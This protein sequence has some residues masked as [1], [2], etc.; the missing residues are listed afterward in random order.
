MNLKSR[1][2]SKL[3][4]KYKEIETKEHKLSYVFLEL[5]K[6]C[7]LN[8]L[9]C[10]SDCK[11]VNNEPEL[12][13]ES[14]LKIIDYIFQKY[15]NI[16][17]LILTGGE[18]LIYSNL[19]QILERISSY[20]F[21]WG[22]VTNGM[23]MSE[24]KMEMLLKNTIYSI[25]LSLDGTEK[26]HNKLRNSEISF[27]NT[28]NA[29]KIIEKSD[30]KFK[31]VVTCVYPDNLN[32]LDKIA[33]ILIENKIFNWRLFRIFPSGRAYKNSEIQLSFEQT[34]QIV[35]WIKFS[36]LKYSKLGLNIN[37]SCEGWLPFDEDLKVRDNP[38]FC[39]AGINIASILS[40]G[41]ITGCSN[42]HE[43]FYA[44]NILENDFN[45][46][47]ETKFDKFRKKD[48]LKSTECINCEYFKD[49][50]GN[51]VHLW[52]MQNSKPNFCYV[53]NLEK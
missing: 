32:E 46:I 8:C 49:C 2:L 35:N 44:G 23:N 16:P 25:T 18:P 51:S 4:Y 17:A 28:L 9:H 12:T 24:Q 48:W 3:N 29:L 40:N 45:Y 14:W 11:S 39:R 33:E 1:I 10:G 37:F 6:K 41:I 31:D 21:R 13:L 15:S 38:F 26:S 22:I 42:N 50:N 47:W 34:Q 53:K 19:Q 27:Q 5:S 36:K 7:N 43:S 20:N 52:N 30:I